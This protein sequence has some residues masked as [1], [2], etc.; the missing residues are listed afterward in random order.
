MKIP[1]LSITLIGIALALLTVKDLQE[2][3]GIRVLSLV[4][5]IFL[6]A[7]YAERLWELVLPKTVL[8]YI[9]I[10][11]I[12]LPLISIG[13]KGAPSIYEPYLMMTVLCGY[14]LVVVPYSLLQKDLEW[15]GNMYLG[16]IIVM[17]GLCYLTFQRQ[18][19]GSYAMRTFSDF[20][21]FFALQASIAVPFLHG[22]YRN[23]LRAFMLITLLLTFSR[24]SFFLSLFVVIFQIF[25]ENKARF[26]LLVPAFSA[27]VA[28]YFFGTAAG[29]L[30]LTKMTKLGNLDSANYQVEAPDQSD[31]ARVACIVTTIQQLE[32]KRLILL[33]HGIK[34]NHEII[35]ENLDTFAW[36][37]DP[38]L[39]DA[40]VHNV[41]IEIISDT[42]LLGLVPFVI[43]IFYV[44]LTIAR[45]LGVQSKY[46]MSLTIFAISYMF[47]GNYVTFFFQYTMM[48]FL[49]VAYEAKLRAP[50]ELSHGSGV[51]RRFAHLL[52][53]V[54]DANRVSCQLSAARAG[55]RNDG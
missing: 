10:S 29:N 1:P 44:G 52:L 15:L 18:W 26:M 50:V 49:F 35:G 38:A 31:L 4:I 30:M 32:S 17:C 5:P 48:Y 14:I 47:E 27:L 43:C 22:R 28:I 40:A 45:H 20:R 42:G 9:V 53:P 41:Y 36:G 55:K 6:A 7:G 19:F 11:C 39:A 24:I 12:I 46:F 37:L 23:L 16:A 8:T 33:G 2:I 21:T 51:A 3:A 13:T 25:K 54:P 34:T